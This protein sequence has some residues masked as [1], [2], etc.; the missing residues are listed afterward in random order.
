MKR[1]Q[2]LMIQPENVEFDTVFIWLH[3]LGDNAMGYH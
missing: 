3:G 2:D 1:G